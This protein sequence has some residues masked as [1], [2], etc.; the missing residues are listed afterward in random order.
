[1]FRKKLVPLNTKVEKRE[2]RR[3]VLTI[4]YH[5]YHVTI[6]SM[7]AQAKALIAARVETAIEK[8]L[9]ERLKKGTVSS[10]VNSASI[11]AADAV[12]SPS[13]MARFT[14]SHLLL[15]RRLLRSR[16]YRKK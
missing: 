16:S 4:N 12:S 14:T 1:M 7:F 5:K 6:M 9:L 15:L 10:L 2:K 8:E 13:S 3:E 11:V